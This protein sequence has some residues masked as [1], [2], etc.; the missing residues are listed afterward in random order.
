MARR[1]TLVKLL[2]MYRSECRLSLN[3]AHNAQ[4]RDTQVQR[5][6]RVQD[7]LWADFAWPLLRVDRKFPVQNGQ[8]YYDMPEDLDIDRISRIE[9]YHDA[10]YCKLLPGIDSEHYTAYNSDLDERQWPPLRWKITEDEQL[11][12]WPI[13]DADGSETTQEGIV[14]ITGI[15]Q[16]APLVDDTDRADLDD[17]LI[18]L[19]CAAE[20]L[21]A[22]GAKDAQLKLDQANKRYAKLRGAQMPRRSFRMFGAGQKQDQR[23]DRLPIAVYNSTG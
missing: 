14:K 4:A 11:E 19:F 15:K 9:V 22:A 17:R 20:H 6:Q 8:R 5:I 23:H 13:P 3:P 18:I 1:T 7:W 12:I 21:A 10:A 16:L 2:D